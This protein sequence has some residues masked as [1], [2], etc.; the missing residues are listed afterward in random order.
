[1][2]QWNL[3]PGYGIRLG[4]GSEI[5]PMLSAAYIANFATTCTSTKHRIV[6]ERLGQASIAIT[7]DSC[8]HVLP[9]LQEAAAERFDKL[10]ARGNVGKLL[11]CRHC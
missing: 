8:S 7:P 3:L 5:S 2:M 4:K 10:G 9:G 6:S 1:M 11:G